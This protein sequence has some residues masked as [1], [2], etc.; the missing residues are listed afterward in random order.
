MLYRIID[1]IIIQ[2]GIKKSL[3]NEAFLIHKM[4]TFKIDNLMK[5]LYHYA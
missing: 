2:L 3:E 4:I 5:M 1:I